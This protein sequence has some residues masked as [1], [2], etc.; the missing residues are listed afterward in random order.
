MSEPYLHPESAAVLRRLSAGQ[1]LAEA[2]PQLVSHHEA[3]D[4]VQ[5]VIQTGSLAHSPCPGGDNGQAGHVFVDYGL[6]FRQARGRVLGWEQS[7]GQPLPDQLGVELAHALLQCRAHLPIR[8]AQ[9]RDDAPDGIPRTDPEQAAVNLLKF[10][11]VS[12]GQRFAGR[13]QEQPAAPV[14]A[15]ALARQLITCPAGGA[16]RQPDRDVHHDR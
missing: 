1:S 3:H 6:P 10:D 4:G 11:G 16:V 8:F 14:S 12:G 15:L 5:D 7:R 13:C 2:A 9:F